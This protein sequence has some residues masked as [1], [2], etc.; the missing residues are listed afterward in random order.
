MSVLRGKSPAVSRKS[1]FGVLK[2][3]QKPATMK[4]TRP[5]GP[6]LGSGAGG[7]QASGHERNFGA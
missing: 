7:I 1:A 5:A 3:E 2:L 4:Q 6:G